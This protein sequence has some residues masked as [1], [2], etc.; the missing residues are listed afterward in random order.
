M[1]L[2]CGVSAISAATDN[3]VDNLTSEMDAMDGSI[4]VSNDEKAIGVEEDSALNAQEN[5][6]IYGQTQNG[7]VA[8][9]NQRDT[10]NLSENSQ[11]VIFSSDDGENILSDS[12][13][14]KVIYVDGQNNASDGGNGSSENPFSSLDLACMNVAGESKVVL[15]IFKYKLI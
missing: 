12:Y 15:N 2:L 13:S 5:D 7:G 1:V 8:L 14:P 3:A 11:N 6:M 9:Q 10:D 4:S